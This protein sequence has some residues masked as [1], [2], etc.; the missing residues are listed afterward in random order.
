MTETK[1][2]GEAND[3]PASVT[4]PVAAADSAGLA[5]DQRTH[6]HE[7]REQYQDHC[8][9]DAIG[10]AIV[11]ITDADDQLL[12]LVS[13]EEKAAVLPNE[14]VAPGEDWATVGREWVEGVAGIDVTIDGIERVRR[15]DHEIEGEDSPESTI[16]HV[17]FCGSAPSETA[18]DGLCADNPFE[19]GWHDELPVAEEESA[20]VADVR[21]F[22]G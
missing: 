15:V 7:N 9:S 17:V 18:I 3:E 8:E 6:V 20:H 21:L 22:I 5:I 19:L 11:G 4:D 12:L 2:S 1:R 14:T 13:W 10:R 16:Y